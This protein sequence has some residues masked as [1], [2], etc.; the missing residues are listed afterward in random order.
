MVV[1]STAA[2]YYYLHARAARSRRLAKWHVGGG[3]FESG[4]LV[5]RGTRVYSEPRRHAGLPIIP[6]HKCIPKPTNRQGLVVESIAFDRAYGGEASTKAILLGT[7]RGQIYETALDY[8]SSGSATT[9]GGGSASASSAS[10]AALMGGGGGGGGEKERP[11][12]KVRWVMTTPPGQFTT[13]P[14]MFL[15][16]HTNRPPLNAKQNKTKKQVHELEQPLPIRALEFELLRDGPLDA[17]TAEPTGTTGGAGGRLLLVLAATS[18]PVRLYKFL[19][20]PAFEALFARYRDGLGSLTFQDFGGCVFGGFVFGLV[21][22][23]H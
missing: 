9:L 1:A 11:V 5:W 13:H 22:F 16:T 18:N 15:H 2:E 19:G 4:F 23:G 8:S 14:F 21:C 17:A 7:D 10:A 3:V 20:G 6:F 12:V